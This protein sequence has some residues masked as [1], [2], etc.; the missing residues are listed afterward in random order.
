MDTFSLSPPISFR[1]GGKGMLTVKRFEATNSVFN[2][3]DE[4][5]SFSVSTPR[6][7][8]P[9]AAKKMLRN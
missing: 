6:Y 7:Y 8:V 4:N 3:I 2:V 1:E 9:R 5:R